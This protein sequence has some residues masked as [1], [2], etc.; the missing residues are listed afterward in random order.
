MKNIS[1]YELACG[2]IQRKENAGIWRTLWQEHTVYHVRE[3]N[4]NTGQRV[5]WDVFEKLTDAR[6][7]FSK[8]EAA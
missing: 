4:F 5:F 6:K 1:R 8:R 3:H 7:R 2:Y